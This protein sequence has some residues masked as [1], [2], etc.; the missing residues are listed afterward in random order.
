MYKKMK[1]QEKPPEMPECELTTP[2]EQ[3]DK[4]DREGTMGQAI[5]VLPGSKRYKERY[6][7]IDW[8][9]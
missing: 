9:K 7:Q 1:N 5:Y 2:V 3:W 6:D 8:T 4:K